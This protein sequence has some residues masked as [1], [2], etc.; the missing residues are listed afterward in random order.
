MSIDPIFRVPRIW[1]NKEL[2]KIAPLVQGVVANVSGW[3]D[4]DKEGLRYREYFSNAKEYYITNY[5]S[6]ARGFQGNLENEIFLDLTQ[7]LQE[8]LIHKFDAVLNHTVLEHIYE[9]NAALD[10]LCELSKDLMIIVVPFLQEEHADYGD[11]WRFTP[12]C[13]KRL[14]E[15]RGFSVA[16]I[17]FNK[18]K[19]ASIYVFVVACRRVER[20]SALKELD[21]NMI[22][23]IGKTYAGQGAIKRPWAQRA[24]NVAKRLIGK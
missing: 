12:S 7:P 18:H 15:E 1:S 11:Y 21:G 19:N 6:G 20:W 14:L 16:Y 4:E 3:K 8:E 10:T 24:R 13:L 5:I 2:R 9:V 17:S 22:E 23:D